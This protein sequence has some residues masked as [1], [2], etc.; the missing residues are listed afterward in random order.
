MTW[1][2][3]LSA[4]LPVI[5]TLPVQLCTS[6]AISLTVALPTALLKGL[7]FISPRRSISNF[8]HGNLYSRV[9]RMLFILGIDLIFRKQLE[10]NTF[11]RLHCYLYVW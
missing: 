7:E 1:L 6:V 3:S 5:Q 10:K 9:R 4:C 2:I 8:P 11:R